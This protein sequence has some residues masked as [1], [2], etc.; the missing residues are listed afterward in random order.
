M[1]AKRQ[2]KSVRAKKRLPVQVW[3]A[4]TEESL[5]GTTKDVSADGIFV[6]TQKPFPPGTQVVIEMLFSGKTIKL[7][8]VVQQSAR[9]AA[10]MQSVQTS[11]MGIKAELPG[12]FVKDVVGD[13]RI[14]P[15]IPVKIDVVGFMEVKNI[16]LN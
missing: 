16:P 8:G 15:R 6:Q 12:E 7:E 13:R 4:G 5:S 9:V 11:G 3:K 2:R 10:A 14:S 1:L